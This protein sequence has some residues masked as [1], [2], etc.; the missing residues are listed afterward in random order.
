MSAQPFSTRSS[1]TSTTSP[2]ASR[3]P[4]RVSTSPFT[5]TS[6]PWIATFASPPLP[7]RS[8]AL[9]A[10]PS[11]IPG[12]SCTGCATFLAQRRIAHRHD[13]VQEVGLLRPL[14]VRAGHDE[15]RLERLVEPEDDLLGVY[16]RDAVEQIVRVEGDEEVVLARRRQPLVGLPH[17]A[18]PHDHLDRPFGEREA[19][20]DR[21]RLAL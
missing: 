16:G 7:T 15:P 12:E 21:R 9:S 18:V 2:S 8:A 4:R 20:R 10:W 13:Q 6:P 11:V 17:L 3:R 5:L 19:H 1:P 14:A